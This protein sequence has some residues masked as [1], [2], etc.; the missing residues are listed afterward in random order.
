MPGKHHKKDRSS[1]N[2]VGSSFPLPS[3]SPNTGISNRRRIKD[4]AKREKKKERRVLE[5]EA[6]EVASAGPGVGPIPRM[7]DPNLD[8][9]GQQ[10]ELLE[11]DLAEARRRSNI[12]RRMER[13]ARERGLLRERRELGLDG[14]EG[15]VV[16][17][18][19]D[20]E[21]NFVDDG[22]DGVREVSN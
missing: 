7:V 2:L 15:S 18:G 1:R 6:G 21:E 19:P 11:H 12:Q 8:E 4:K 13:R 3:G 16:V 17:G 14:D 10:Q 20:V 22:G 5:A 9:A